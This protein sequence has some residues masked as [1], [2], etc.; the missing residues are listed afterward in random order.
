MT[1]T[2]AKARWKSARVREA[3]ARRARKRAANGY[4]L[5]LLLHALALEF[6]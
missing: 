1:L 2:Y 4:A 6:S 5:D 3:W